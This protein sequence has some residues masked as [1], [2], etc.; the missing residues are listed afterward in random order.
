[1]KTP[2][3]PQ[4]ILE[5]HSLFQVLCEHF[6]IATS[7]WQRSKQVA[8]ENTCTEKCGFPVFHQWPSVYCHKGFSDLTACQ[9]VSILFHWVSSGHAAEHGCMRDSQVATEVTIWTTSPFSPW[10]APWM[11]SFTSM[12]V[13]RAG[14]SSAA[15]HEREEKKTWRTGKQRETKR[16]TDGDPSHPAAPC[17]C[18]IVGDDHSE[19]TGDG[20]RGMTREIREEMHQREERGLRKEE[21]QWSDRWRETWQEMSRLYFNAPWLSVWSLSDS[22]RYC[23]GKKPL[24]K[25]RGSWLSPGMMTTK[26][27]SLL[28]HMHA[29]GSLKHTCS[30]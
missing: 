16:L 30:I 5:Y 13:G 24:K 18:V 2:E 9:T 3:R 7:G 22:A 1:M 19:C 4:L 15:W 11:A 29:K 21:R 10:M 17:S 27:D 6:H 26:S 8:G 28:P 25:M 14:V 12:S 20:S 23:V